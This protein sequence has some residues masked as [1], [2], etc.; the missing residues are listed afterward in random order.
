MWLHPKT[1]DHATHTMYS[2]VARLIQ[3]VTRTDN[4]IQLGELMM[5]TPGDGGKPETYQKER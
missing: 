4:I 5:S 3:L 1:Y 2:G